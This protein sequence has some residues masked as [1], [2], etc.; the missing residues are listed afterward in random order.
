MWLKMI[1]LT[2]SICLIFRTLFFSFHTIPEKSEVLNNTISLLLSLAEGVDQAR[3]KIHFLPKSG[4][5]KRVV[6][7]EIM[8]ASELIEQIQCK[9][10][11]KSFIE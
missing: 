2:F 3:T 7:C 8:T 1:Q 10:N 4:E 9:S 11:Y 5:R 6:V